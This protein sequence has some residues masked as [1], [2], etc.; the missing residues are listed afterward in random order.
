LNEFIRVENVIF[1]LFLLN[2][3]GRWAGR[4]S[5]WSTHGLRLRLARG[6][7][8]RL[9]FGLWIGCG[10]DLGLWRWRVRLGFLRLALS[11]EGS[12]SRRLAF[13]ERRLFGVRQFSGHDS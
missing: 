1:F 3:S 2:G 12:S 8:L 6:L 13:L 9:G 7:R 11:L 10:N 5:S 4:S